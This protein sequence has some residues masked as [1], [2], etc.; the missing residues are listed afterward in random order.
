MIWNSGTT[1][2]I[3]R[4]WYTYRCSELIIQ[5]TW[6]ATS[7]STQYALFIMCCRRWI[8]AIWDASANDNVLRSSKLY[9]LRCAN[10][11]KW[12][13]RQLS[14]L[15]RAINCMLNYFH[16]LIIF[17]FFANVIINIKQRYKILWDKLRYDTI[18]ISLLRGN[19]IIVMIVINK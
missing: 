9:F 3:S 4:N 16:I 13:F 14:D 15:L 5:M 18:D 11:G 17:K 1:M 2:S 6:D 12:H 8:Y 7:Y 10:P 19:I